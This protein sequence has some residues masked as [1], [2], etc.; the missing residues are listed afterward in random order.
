MSRTKRKWKWKKQ[1]LGLRVSQ[2][3]R[4]KGK[5]GFVICKDPPSMQPRRLR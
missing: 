1:R 4:K 5:V 2:A 3:A